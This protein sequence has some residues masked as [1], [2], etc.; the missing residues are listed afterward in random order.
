MRTRKTFSDILLEVEDA[1][2]ARVAARARLANRMAKA[3]ALPPRSGGATPAPASYAKRDAR[4]RCYALKIRALE[5]GIAAF[6]HHYAL[7]S[8]EEGGRLIGI[9]WLHRAGFHLPAAAL[10]AGT[11][12]WL[13]HE[14]RRIVDRMHRMHPMDR[15]A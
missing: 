4:R 9:C 14:R 10:G 1:N 13:D 7:A 15:A 11:N 2:S 8:V 3:A 5:H 6:P 12:R